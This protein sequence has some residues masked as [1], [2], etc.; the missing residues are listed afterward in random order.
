M[1]ST[2]YRTLIKH[3]WG[4]VSAYLWPYSVFCVIIRRAQWKNTPMKRMKVFRSML[5]LKCWRVYLESGFNAHACIIFFPLCFYILNMYM[6]IHYTIIWSSNQTSFFLQT[7]EFDEGA[8]A[9]LR[10]Q[11]L[12]APRDE[13]IYECVAENSEGEVSVQAKLTI[14]RGKTAFSLH[15]SAVLCVWLQVGEKKT[16]YT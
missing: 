3:I 13:N 5:E 15:I 2:P 12:R 7:I 4:Q 10:I 9:V 6:L 8:G 16:L 11:P 1:V 14:I